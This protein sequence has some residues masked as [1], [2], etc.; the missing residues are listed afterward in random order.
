MRKEVFTPLETYNE[1]AIL[2]LLYA[3]VSKSK[4]L[5]KFNLSHIFIFETHFSFIDFEPKNNLYFI[6][7]LL[8][9]LKK[10]NWCEIFPFTQVPH[11]SFTPTNVT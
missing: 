11:V 9:A 7:L 8:I 1:P 4:E 3:Q 10:K 6:D 2:D 5:Q